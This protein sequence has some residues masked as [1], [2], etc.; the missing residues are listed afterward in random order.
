LLIWATGC[1]NNSVRIK[2]VFFAA[3]CSQK[4]RACFHGTSLAGVG[5]T[6]RVMVARTTLTVTL[7]AISTSISAAPSATFLTVPI[8]PPAGG[9]QLLGLRL[10][11][12]DQQE[13]EH[14]RDQHQGRELQQGRSA[15]GGRGAGGLGVGGGK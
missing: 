15:A 6:T 11:R 7:G 8:I 2:K 9:L 3:F 5:F 1:F 14:D 4:R 10:L 13:I 12:P